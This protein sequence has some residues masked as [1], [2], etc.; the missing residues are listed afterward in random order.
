MA[1]VKVLWAL[2][3]NLGEVMRL[4]REIKAHGK[5]QEVTPKLREAFRE[6]DAAKLNDI[7]RS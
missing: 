6:K 4:V 7:F 1:W 3:S 5:V 2:V